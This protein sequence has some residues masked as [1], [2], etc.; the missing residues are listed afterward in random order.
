MEESKAEE[1]RRLYTIYRM[2][3]WPKKKVASFY[4]V[5]SEQLREWWRLYEM[6]RP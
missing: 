5:T 4:K 2:T 6:S 1:K 3:F